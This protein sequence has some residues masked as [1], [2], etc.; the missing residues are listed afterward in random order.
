VLAGVCS[1]GVLAGLVA[2]HLAA[3]ERLDRLAG[4][5]FAVTVLD[6]R[7]A[8]VPAALADRYLAAAATAMSRRRGYLDGRRLA[9]TFAWLR[10]DDLIWQYWV[11]NYLLGREPPAFDI[12]YWNADTTRMPARLHADLVDL[13]V[14]NRLATPDAAIALGTPVDLGKV[15]V[16]GYLVAGIADHITPWPSCYRS[17]GLLGGDTRF[18]L[19]TSGHIAAMVNPPG[20]AKATY[21]TNPDSPADPQEWLRGATTQQGSWWP[22]F[23][24]WLGRRCGAQKSAPRRLGGRGLG[25]LI[26]APGTYLL[27]R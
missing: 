7:R 10:P 9:E 19:S 20:N 22:D 25:P 14:H 24:E 11:N 1:G 6:Q 18:V 16:D 5:A 2:A 12:L 27:D 15:D 26:E 17:T 21:R 8:G 23:A 4:V 3:T 13:A